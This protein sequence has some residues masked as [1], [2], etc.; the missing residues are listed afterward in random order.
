MIRVDT[1]LG[2]DQ[3]GKTNERI[4]PQ[5]SPTGVNT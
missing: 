5:F 4:S 1:R 3:K 2:I